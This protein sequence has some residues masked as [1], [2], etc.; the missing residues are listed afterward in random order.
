MQFSMYDSVFAHWKENNI[1]I[2]L[3]KFLM[4]HIYCFLASLE[5]YD[6]RTFFE[7]HP[8]ISYKQQVPVDFVVSSVCERLFFGHLRAK[9]KHFH[10]LRPWDERFI[11]ASY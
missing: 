7:L 9:V 1:S 8:D 6:A 2:I 11:Y 5:F 4:V 3:F 10:R